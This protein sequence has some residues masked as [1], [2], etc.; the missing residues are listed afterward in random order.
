MVTERPPRNIYLHFLD[1][2]LN[3]ASS[4][5]PESQILRRALWTLT[6]TQKADLY[7]GLSAVWENDAL[8]AD[9][10]ADIHFLY[11]V[12]Q[13]WPVSHDTSLDA[14]LTSRNVAYEHDA[15]RYPRYFSSRLELPWLAPRWEKETGSTAPLLRHLSSWGGRLVAAGATTLTIPAMGLPVLEGLKRRENQAV[16]FSYF[17]PLVR[18]VGPARLVETQLR[19]QI[20]VGFTEDNLRYFAGD[21]ATGISS[22]AYFDQLEK[23]FPLADLPL[24]NHLLT[25]AGFGELAIPR[26]ELLDRWHSLV[27][28]RTTEDFTLAASVFEWVL[29]GLH[30]AYA[31]ETAALP[32]DARPEGREVFRSWAQ[33]HIRGASA[34]LGRRTSP[35]PPQLPALDSL[36]I[37]RLNLQALAQ[38]LTRR[39]P[40]IM[41]TLGT[42]GPMSLGAVDVLLVT[43]NDTETVSL[44]SHLEAIAGAGHQRF[45]ATNTYWDYGTVAGVSV[46]H[47]RTAMGSGGV[48]G[49]GQAVRDALDERHPSS[50]IAVGVAFG[51]DEKSQPIGTVLISQKLTSYEPQRVGETL[52]GET[53]IKDS[54]D[55][56]SRTEA[57]PRLVSRF[58]D[59]G[60]ESLG[61]HLEVG[62]VLSGEKLIDNAAFKAQLRS[63]FPDAIGGEMEGA[64]IQAACGRSNVE[65]LVVKGVCDYAENKG[66]NKRRRQQIAADAASAAVVR[67]L[68]TGGLMKHRK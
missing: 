34:R 56:G 50:V 17:A 58:R 28:A 27:V 35:I 55:R 64:G 1:R 48:G 46:S 44:R 61:L 54:R 32:P 42:G 4:A 20:S 53:L 60:L 65:W 18:D 22:L 25:A 67:V 38:E 19:Q 66:K 39:N 49:S 3:L 52:V 11:Q 10:I 59:G 43:V 13:I 37:C 6:L 2:E 15:A 23:S 63:H 14:F 26:N 51:M 68:M 12:D 7:C 47:L 5:R 62:E 33:N 45:G 36:V 21:I 40:Y 30:E 41:A 8:D 9:V 24:L 16:T 29:T 31:A 57:S